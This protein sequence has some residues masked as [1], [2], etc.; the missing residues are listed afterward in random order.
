MVDSKYL[1]HSVAIL[2][3]HHDKFDNDRCPLIP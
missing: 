2:V 3:Q 1:A